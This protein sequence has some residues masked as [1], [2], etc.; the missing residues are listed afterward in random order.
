MHT[1]RFSASR[2]SVLSVFGIGAA[3]AALASCGE[4][5][6]GAGGSGSSDD[7]GGSGE[8]PL[9]TT[10]CYPMDYLVQK[11]GGDLVEINSLAKPGVDPHGLE[12]S[13][14]EVASLESSALILQIIGY[15]SALDEAISSR[16]LEDKALE[17]STVIDLLPNTGSDHDHTHDHDHDH[18]DDGHDHDH[19][20]DDHDHGTD[21]SDGGG[22]HDHADDAHDDHAGHDHGQYDPHMWHDPHLMAELGDAL[23]ERLA[24]LDP[25]NAQ[26]YLD[27]AE[28]LHSEL[29]D[30]DEELKARFDGASG[31]KTFVT[32]HTAFA[33]LA[34]HY[35]LHQVG[36]AGVDPETE[37]SPQRLIE[38]ESVI[39]EAGVNT[40][41]FETTASPK[42]AQALADNVG[43][44]SEE[45]DNLETQLNP[46]ADYPAV[47]RENC[48]KLV[49]S[50][51]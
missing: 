19:E 49:A 16:G 20:D 9:V 42:V 32:S 7:G 18:E 43:I 50:W 25:D 6:T 31:S 45:L 27:N 2:R 5:G 29:H 24:E 34:A 40:I 10:T 48:E 23:G 33:Y 35:G 26:T 47:M 36:I 46:D 1:P 39:K 44:E 38:L 28:A 30:L 14:R 41:F 21:A 22:E 12:L 11:V 4:G 3:A 15:Q 37:P 8:K 51:E 17:A 13:V